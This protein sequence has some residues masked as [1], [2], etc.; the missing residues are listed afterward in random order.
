[1]EIVMANVHLDTEFRRVLDNLAAPGGTSNGARG[2]SP[3]EQQLL[4]R[5][6][7]RTLVH[8]PYLAAYLDKVR[9]LARP[10]AA[11]LDLLTDEQVEQVA[12]RGL[13][14]LPF[15]QVRQLALDLPTLLALRDR[16]REELPTSDYWWRLTKEEAARRGTLRSPRELLAGAVFSSAYLDKADRVFLCPEPCYSW[17]EIIN[18]APVRS[19]QGTVRQMS[20][21]GRNTFRGFHRVNR[22]CPGAQ[23]EFRA[24]FVGEQARLAGLLALVRI[25]DDL[26]KLQNLICEE[27]RG[28][29]RNVKQEQLRSYNKVRKP[30]DLYIEHLVA[31]AA[32]L[33]SQRAAL[34]PLLFVPLD[35]QVLQHPDLFTEEELAHLGLSRA[36]T[37]KDV[38]TEGGYLELQRLLQR[39]AD[40]VA[41]RLGRPFPPIYFDLVWNNRYKN[42]GGNLFETNP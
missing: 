29:L 37:Y 26:H 20:A 12:A 31:M 21:V 6:L 24:Y 40:A 1:V 11:D 28:R 17:Q 7:E 38:T 39:R 4:V 33:N 5:E 36:S 23:E 35:S 30:V 42:W 14:G 2:V 3:E 19:S 18:G 13:G 34:T 22:S 15:E 32:E 10:S 8:P 25:R 27:V 41:T 9:P 16:I